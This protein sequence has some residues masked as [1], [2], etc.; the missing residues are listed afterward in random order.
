MKNFDFMPKNHIFSNCG[1]RRE[2]IWGISCEKSRFYAKKSYFS[3]ILGGGGARAGCA[4]P[5]GSAPEFYL[6][7]IMILKKNIFVWYFIK[8]KPANLYYQSWQPSWLVDWL[9]GHNFRKISPKDYEPN[10]D[11][12]HPVVLMKKIYKFPPVRHH[13]DHL[14]CR[15]RSLHNFGRGPP[16]EY[17]IFF[18]IYPSLALW[19]LR[20]SKYEKLKDNRC[21][22]IGRAHLSTDER[23]SRSL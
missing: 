16:K 17:H 23:K 6:L 8:I 12:F 15:A 13:G 19:F 11:S 18:Y 10:L 2:N 14:A 3:P 20:R 1:G 9:N 5:P 22:V 7:N 21:Q 4:H